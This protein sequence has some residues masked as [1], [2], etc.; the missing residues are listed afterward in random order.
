MGADIDFC[1]KHI[2]A[3]INSYFLMDLRVQMSIA[4]RSQCFPHGHIIDEAGGEAAKAK[5]RA[6]QEFEAG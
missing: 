3:M 6:T 5:T 4:I 1:K 2:L